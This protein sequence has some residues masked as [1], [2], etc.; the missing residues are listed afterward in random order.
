M[1]ATKH[2]MG[3]LLLPR[4]SLML[5][6]SAFCSRPPVYSN[7]EPNPYSTSQVT[8]AVKT[9][10]ANAEE[11]GAIP[12]SGRCPGGGHGNPLQYSCLEKVHEQRR[13]AGY[14]QRVKKSWT[15]LHD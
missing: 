3:N 14:S 9:L 8:L 13:L 7:R 2:G 1:M 11:A 4:S 6:R 15:R 12:G 5:R 10:P